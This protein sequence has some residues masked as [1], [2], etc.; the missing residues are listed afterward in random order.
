SVFVAPAARRQGV[1]TA[2][3]AALE[4]RL[5]A[6]GFA[7]VQA[8]YTTGKTGTV[9]VEAI[10]A[11]RGWTEPAT[12]TVLVQLAPRE[13]VASDLFS[14]QRMAALDPGF[15]IFRWADLPQGERAALIASDAE[16]PW[17]TPGLAVWKYDGEPYDREVS[18]GARYR[19]T[20]VGWV[21][22]Q[23]IDKTNV[24]YLASFLRKDLSHRGRILPLYRDS[25]LRAVAAGRE[26]A[27]FVTPVIY[28]TMIRF[29][30]RWM[31]PHARLVAETRGATK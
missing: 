14:P 23:P 12:R 5:G 4:E 3:F 17:V 6:L 9:G 8:V 20:V 15:E 10:L 16:K 1:A 2:L 19:G 7:S 22:A 13:F 27:T 25:L 30:H 26:L 11:R 21:L 29:I 24:R 31:A 28:P 18:V